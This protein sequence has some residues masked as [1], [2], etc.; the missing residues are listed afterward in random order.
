VREGERE[1][2]REK[3]RKKEKEKI[4]QFEYLFSNMLFSILENNIK[5]RKELYYLTETI[6]G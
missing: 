4:E 6:D 2:E 5:K 3:E 1:R